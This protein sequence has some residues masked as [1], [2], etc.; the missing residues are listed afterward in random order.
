M[1]HHRQD[2][3]HLQ[4]VLGKW[5]E[6]LHPGKTERVPLGLS[7]QDAAHLARVDPQTLNTEAKLL[8]AWITHDASQS[9]DTAKRTQRAKQ[10]WSKLWKQAHRLTLPAKTLGKLF[11]SAV[12]STMLYSAECRAFTKQEIK[13][14]QTFVNH[15]TLGMLNVRQRRMHDEEVTMVDLRRRLGIPSVTVAIGVRQLRWLGHVAR[16]PDERLEKQALWLWREHH[17][18]GRRSR[19]KRCRGTIDTAAGLWSVLQDF[20]Q[21]LGLPPQ[22]WSTQW[23]LRAQSGN[24]KVWRSDLRNGNNGKRSSKTRTYGRHVMHLEAAPKRRLN[25]GLAGGLKWPS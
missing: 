25:N 23:V 3:A 5:G 19:R 16:L 20:Q 13:R 17:G 12:M 2:E 1:E 6:E 15:C 24:G 7:V 18:P 4:G 21:T 22:T 10:L 8:G 11:E 14:M 9:V